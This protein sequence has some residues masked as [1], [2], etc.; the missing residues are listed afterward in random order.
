[1]ILLR[2]SNAYF[3]TTGAVSAGLVLLPLIYAIISYRKKGGFVSSDHLV[4]ALDTEIIEEKTETKEIMDKVKELAV[5]YNPLNSSRIKIGIGIGICGILLM[6]S[7]SSFG[8]SNDPIYNFSRL[9]KN[10][11]EATKIAKEYLLNQGFNLDSYQS[12][13]HAENWMSSDGIPLNKEQNKYVAYIMENGGKDKLRHFLSEDKLH[14][15]GWAVRF[16]IPETKREYKVWV[17]AKGEKFEYSRTKL[18]ADFKETL[19][20]TAYLPFIGQVEALSLVREFAK[21]SDIDLS[22]MKLT[23]EEIIEKDNRTDYH[24]KFKGNDNHEDTIGGAKRTFAFNVHGNHI[25]MVEQRIKLPE[26]WEREFRQRTLYDNIHIFSF[27]FILLGIIVLGTRYLLQLIK[28]NKPNWKFVRSFAILSFILGLI[29][30]INMATHL[31]GYET[32]KPLNIFMYQHYSNIVLGS[33]GFAMLIAILILAIDM[34]W[35]RHFSTFNKVKRKIYIKDALISFLCSI[36]LFSIFGSVNT[37]LTIYHP[38]FLGAHIFDA[39]QINSHFPLLAILNE[40]TFQM[41]LIFMLLIT[42]M[43]YIYDRLMAQKGRSKI[44]VLSIIAIPFILPAE[45]EI[46]SFIMNILW[47]GCILFLIKYFW[48]FNPIS[49]VLGAFCIG[50]LPDIINYLSTIQDPSYR[51]QVFAAI[52]CIGI[53]FLYLLKESFSAPKTAD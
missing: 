31:W 7:I 42:G 38:S 47:F 46:L 4:N 24:F 8:K 11:T 40:D 48:R 19:S 39:P 35:P 5:S 44:L 25:G 52:A 6:Y 33:F 26:V 12:V 1:M 2:S 16:F 29:E 28:D 41:T 43:I 3:I 51:N 53:F 18:G 30:S 32:S 23:K 22:N 50:T 13:A 34:A 21:N 17:A 37:L 15:M 45:P 14:N 27:L 9:D 36:G 10:R 20:D 49:F